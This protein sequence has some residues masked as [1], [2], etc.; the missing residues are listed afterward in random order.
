MPLTVN[1]PALD[2]IEPRWAVVTYIVG[3]VIDAV[4]ARPLTVNV[5]ALAVMEPTATIDVLAVM[6]EVLDIPL[7]VKIPP[8]AVMELAIELVM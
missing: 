3:V 8:L 4:L 6:V 5:P 1:T 7:M 2:V